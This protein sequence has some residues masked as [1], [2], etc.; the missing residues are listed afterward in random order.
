[1]EMPATRMTIPAT[2]MPATQMPATR[3]SL[4]I[5]HI[6]IVSISIAITLQRIITVPPTKAEMDAAMAATLQQASG[7]AVN[8]QTSQG[9]AVAEVQGSQ[10]AT[11][12]PPTQIAQGQHSTADSG[13]PVFAI[14]CCGLVFHL[15]HRR[16]R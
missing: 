16:S 15:A 8:G 3:T 14:G 6:C 7:N 10:V 5:A 13:E 11:Q 12:G 9:Q 1:M 2:R 4:I